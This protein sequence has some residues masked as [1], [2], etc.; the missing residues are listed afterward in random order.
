MYDFTTVLIPI[1]CAEIVIAS[2][3]L[4]VYNIYIIGETGTI[5]KEKGLNYMLKILQIQF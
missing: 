4:R 5:R 1:K 3:F 2:R